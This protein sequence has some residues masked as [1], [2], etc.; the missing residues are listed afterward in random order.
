MALIK[1]S[2]LVVLSALIIGCSRAPE[3]PHAIAAVKAKGSQVSPPEQISEEQA[4]KLLVSELKVHKVQDVECLSFFDESNIPVNLKADL[5]EF[6]GHEIH[7]D[8]C[9]GDPAVSHVRDRYRVSSTGKVTVYSTANEEYI[10][11]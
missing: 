2:P 3:L 7:N 1:I 8:K 11:L 9:G 6:A 5:W 4:L 10:P